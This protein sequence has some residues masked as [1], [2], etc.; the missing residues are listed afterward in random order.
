MVHTSKL[1]KATWFGHIMCRNCL[2]KHVVEGKT[3]GRVEVTGRRGRRCK[4]LLNDLK[5][6]RGYNKL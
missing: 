2:L 5:V 6:A 3:E 1:S 4:H